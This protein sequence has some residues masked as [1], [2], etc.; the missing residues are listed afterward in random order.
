MNSVLTCVWALQ[1]DHFMR[2]LY[3]A[4]GVVLFGCSP[5]SSE[6]FHKEGEVLCRSL[7]ETLQEIDS[8]DQ[9]LSKET[10]LKKKF[11]SLVS[12][13]IDASR[14]QERHPD[15]WGAE[16]GIEPGLISVSLKEQL[17]R[18][19]LLEG[20]R[21]IVERAQQE[22]LVKLDAYERSRLKQREKLKN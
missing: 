5:H 9:L 3:L 8:L 19:Y 18:I 22:S 21:E 13:M 15:N 7:V 11:E 10:L 6:E 1:G 12:L 17:H 16:S 2:F 20:G 4:L 14:F